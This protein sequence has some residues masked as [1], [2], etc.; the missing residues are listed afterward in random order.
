MKINDYN[1]LYIVGQDS[2][3]EAAVPARQC[4]RI[5]PTVYQRTC[6]ADK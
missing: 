5:C 4:Q 3:D 2:R 6:W 1:D